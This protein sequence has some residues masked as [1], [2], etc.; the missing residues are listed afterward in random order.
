[1]CAEYNLNTLIDWLPSNQCIEIMCAEYNCA[2]KKQGI[3]Q[4]GNDHVETN[5]GFQQ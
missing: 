2:G 4:E 5:T 1:M 3:K